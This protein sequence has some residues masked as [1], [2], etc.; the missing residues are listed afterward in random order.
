MKTLILT[1]AA[2][3]L[4]HHVIKEAH[5]GKWRVIGVDKRPIPAN[6]SVPDEFIQTDVF[7][8]NYRD[9]M[10]ADAVVHFAWRTNIFDCLS[11]PRESSR[12]NIDMSVH[13]LEV[14]KI[15]KIPFLVFPSTASLY[16]HTL[17]PWNEESQVEPIEHYS[18]EKLSVENLCRMY[19]RHF[20]VPSVTL[21]FFQVYGECQRKDTSIHIFQEKIRA[22]EPLT[23]FKPK[24]PSLDSPKRDFVY[25]GDVARA[26]MLAIKFRERVTGETVNVCTGRTTSILDIVA[27]MGGTPVMVPGRD[28]DV[29]VHVGDN[30]KA[31]LMLAWEPKVNILD[32]LKGV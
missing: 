24:D 6:H 28:Y 30:T 3:F 26:V 14:C 25:A 29:D 7:D 4:A 22:G 13:L 5:E 21:R 2:G 27:K 19:A 23:V 12:D 15:A 32:W 1:G 17:P 16:S 9:L 11:H 31:R 20:S 18:W 10:G 8:L